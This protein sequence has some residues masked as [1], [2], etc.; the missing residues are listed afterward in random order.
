MVVRFMP[1]SVA[2]LG[3][4][5][6]HNTWCREMLTVY[7]YYTVVPLVQ[8]IVKRLMSAVIQVTQHFIAF[9]QHLKDPEKCSLYS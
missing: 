2:E 7:T 4:P 5:E 1:V 6:V 8:R 9:T 3:Y